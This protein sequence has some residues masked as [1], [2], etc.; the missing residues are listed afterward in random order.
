MTRLIAWL[1]HIV[2][3]RC[4]IICTKH[5]SD[6][7]TRTEKMRYSSISHDLLRFN[8]GIQLIFTYL[9]QFDYRMPVLR[10]FLF[11]LVFI[12]QLNICTY[13]IEFLV[14]IKNVKTILLV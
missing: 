9:I 8:L 11:F 6:S 7:S 4:G 5:N 12:Y 2:S 1:K 3:T 10:C 13:L 14:L